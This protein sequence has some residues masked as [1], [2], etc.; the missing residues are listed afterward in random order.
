MEKKSEN[1]NLRNIEKQILEKEKRII[2]PHSQEI[3]SAKLWLNVW[4]EED[5]KSWFL[6]PV[7]VIKKIWNLY[8]VIPMTTKWKLES[9]FYY[10]IA[11]VDFGKPSSL[12]V[13]QWRVVDS[14]RLVLKIW[15][16]SNEEYIKIKN[17][18]QKMYLS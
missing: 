9:Q 5:W 12:I 16:I 3:R 2:F 11:S 7:L 13:S 17:I 18:L 10:R 15:K 8:F 6:R 1:Y 14:R 4:C